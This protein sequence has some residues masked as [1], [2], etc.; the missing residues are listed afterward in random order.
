MKI[1]QSTATN[2]LLSEDFARRVVQRVSRI[3]RRRTVRRRAIA[4]TAVMALGLGAFF[5]ERH[6]SI[7]PPQPTVALQTPRSSNLTGDDGAKEQPAAYQEQAQPP[8]NMFL[9]DTYMMTNF[10][11]STGESS[12]HSYD[13]WWNS[14]S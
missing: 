5:A 10:E 11:E 2:R 3:K 13:S 1:N 12:W 4:V 6:G 9:P 14:N 8:I 7:A